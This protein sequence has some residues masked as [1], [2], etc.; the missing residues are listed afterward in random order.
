MDP[1]DSM[2][3]Y[4]MLGGAVGGFINSAA[5]GENNVTTKELVKYYALFAAMGCLSAAIVSTFAAQTTASGFWSGL[6]GGYF[7]VALGN[8]F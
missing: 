1:L 3:V 7:F 5:R 4:G 2:V 8:V 6:I